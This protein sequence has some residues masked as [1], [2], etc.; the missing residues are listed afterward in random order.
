MQ[1]LKYCLPVLLL[2]ALP[3]CCYAQTFVDH[4]ESLQ[5]ILDRLYDEMIPQSSQLID[6]GRALAGFGAL[7]F[8]ANKVYRSLASAEPIDFYPLMRPFGIG[9]CIL[10]YP[11]CLS[12]LG[13]VLKPTVIGTKAMVEKG[14]ASIKRL[15]EE[16]E[17]AMREGRF[18]KM[19]VGPDGE[20]DRDEWM[21]Y[22][23][24]DESEGPLDY[25]ANSIE[26]EMSRMYFKTKTTI[27]QYLS[28]IL[29][30]LYQAAALCINALRTFN[31]VILAMLGPIVLGLSVY[32]GFEHTL[33]VWLAR[34]INVFLWLPVANIFGAII[35]Q[36]QVNMLQY[37]IQEDI[38]NANTF[39]TPTDVAYLIFMIIAIC[40]YFTVPSVAQYIVNV[41]PTAAVTDKGRQVM[42]RMAGVTT[43]MA[44]GA[45]GATIG[46]DA[47]GGSLMSQGGNMGANSQSAPYFNDKPDP[48]RHLKDRLGG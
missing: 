6:V 14:D 20:G 36:I 7:W 35:N 26:F 24:P 43:S 25:I 32:N 17:K 23:H 8:I 34:F 9:L 41:G 11:A 48:H 33:S 1:V 45:I 27:R 5:T 42:G 44:T 10:L 22:A 19:Y 4:I 47:F 16:R 2:L 38:N 40:G 3:A 15:I 29:E 31:L 28:A 39:F 21:K 13:E 18:Y 46:A 12:I 37:A 30:V